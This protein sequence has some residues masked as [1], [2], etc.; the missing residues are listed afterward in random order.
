MTKEEILAMKAGEK[1]S[2]LVRKQIFPQLY[3]RYSSRGCLKYS[4][5]I[6]AAWQVKESL[7]GEGLLL[8]LIDLCQTGDKYVRAEFWDNMGLVPS[9]I[10]GMA[11]GEF[12]PEAICK[13]ALIAKLEGKSL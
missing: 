12:A 10:V 11:E 3:P 13:A 5:D 8:A 4:T 6:L 1:L 7:N 9:K 2:T